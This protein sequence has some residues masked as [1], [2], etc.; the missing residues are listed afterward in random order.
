MTFCAGDSSG[1]ITIA[2]A[3]RRLGAPPQVSHTAFAVA[4]RRTLLS[5]RAM[6]ASRSIQARGSQHQP[7]HRLAAHNVRV[8]N[9]VNVRLSYA[10]IPDG[11]GV[12]HEIRS[13]LALIKATT[14][15]SPDFPLQPSLRQ[16][17]FEQLLEFGLTRRIATPPRMPSRPLVPANKNVMLELRHG[18]S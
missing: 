16:L 17:Q 12:D 8:N 15:I 4:L 11:L 1:D 10:P 18:I 6:F 5:P 9:F 7:L 14:L 13:V 2:K 3:F